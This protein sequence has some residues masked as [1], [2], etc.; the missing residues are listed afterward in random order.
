MVVSREDT[1]NEIPQ[2]LEFEEEHALDSDPGA[3][4]GRETFAP[5]E[6]FVRWPRL[7]L[8]QVKA[9][10]AR[11]RAWGRLFPPRD[12]ARQRLPVSDEWVQGHLLSAAWLA[13][14]RQRL[15]SLS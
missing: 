12:K 11:R 5:I 7:V 3:W 15:Q 8:E 2:P 1:L 6:R 10:R 14:A 4:P 9:A 13:Q